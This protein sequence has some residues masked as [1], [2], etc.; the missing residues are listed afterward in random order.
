MTDGRH[1]VELVG[2]RAAA[3]WRWR[4][5][6]LPGGGGSSRCL[7]VEELPLPGGGGS[8]L[9]VSTEPSD[10]C[11]A[12]LSGVGLS[13]V[14]EPNLSV[15]VCEFP[16]S[17]ALPDGASEFLHRCGPFTDEDWPDVAVMEDHVAGLTFAGE[18]EQAAV[19]AIEAVRI[20]LGQLAGAC[21]TG[22]T[23]EDRW[24]RAERAGLSMA[25]HFAIGSP[26][27]LGW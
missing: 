13:A 19:V 24:G 16:G 18:P 14:G 6:P 1:V 9:S 4:E 11:G 2:G 3:T 22:R 23:E 8:S 17:L 27:E 5:L 12:D 20:G 7:A 15:Q 26:V 21:V 25:I 10:G